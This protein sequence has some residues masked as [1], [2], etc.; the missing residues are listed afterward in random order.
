MR[1]QLH[2]AQQA[3][4]KVCVVCPA[5]RLESL[6]SGRYGIVVRCGVERS[7]IGSRSDPSTL[8][9]RCLSDP[10][11]QACTSWRSEKQRIAEGK[12]PLVGTHEGV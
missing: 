5:G 7:L 6:E 1:Q 11:Y 9:K 3:I 2:R 8:V 12:G 10:G 4:G